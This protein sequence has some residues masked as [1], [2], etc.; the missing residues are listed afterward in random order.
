MAK[1]GIGVS[2]QKM[3][4]KFDGMHLNH[5][6]NKYDEWGEEMNINREA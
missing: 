1:I 4:R 6:T 2:N 3:D 5:P